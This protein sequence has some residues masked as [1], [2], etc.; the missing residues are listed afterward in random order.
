MKHRRG[1]A[2]PPPAPPADPPPA[3]EPATPEAAHLV[4]ER[5]LRHS[6]GPHDRAQYACSC[7]FV[8]HADVSTSVACPHCGTGQAW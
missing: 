6:G 3:V 2:A 7:G 1:P 8:F 5:R 4:N